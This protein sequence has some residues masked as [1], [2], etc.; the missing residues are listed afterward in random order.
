MILAGAGMV[1]LKRSGKKSGWIF[2]LVCLLALP[3]LTV[4]A[5]TVS[6]T[7]DKEIAVTY[8][9]ISGSPEEADIPPDHYIWQGREYQMVS[10]QLIAEENRRQ[11]EVRKR[12]IQ[13][14]QVEQAAKVPETISVSDGGRERI[15]EAAD[16]SYDNWQWIPGFQFPVTVREY[17]AGSFYLGDRVAIVKE[18]QPM[19]GYEEE[20]LE[21]IGVNPDYYRIK[22]SS[23]SGEPWR[24]EEGI[25]FRQAVVS[26]EKYVADVKVVYESRGEESGP[27][28]MA[29]QAVYRLT[30]NETEEQNEEGSLVKV[31]TDSNAGRQQKEKP[32]KQPG[33]LWNW[34]RNL[35]RRTKTV[36]GLGLLLL[37]L[38]CLLLRRLLSGTGRNRPTE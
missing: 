35:S 24:D 12:M 20:L 33:G 34:I 5:E 25:L 18:E 29:Y 14:S 31:R 15:F 37:P 3:A 36:L 13:Y 28:D 30:E 17:D 19:E 6:E 32:P 21:L 4:R 2:I 11:P 9:P 23:W 16:I 26:G 8:D 38:L 1:L 10:C 7:G 27:P 22:N